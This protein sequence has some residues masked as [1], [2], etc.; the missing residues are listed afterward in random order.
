MTKPEDHLSVR[1]R[2]CLDG[3]FLIAM[4]NMADE[5]F[6]RSVVFICAHSD[7]GAMG[8]IINRPQDMCFSELIS[9]LDLQNAD[10]AR[11]IGRAS[12]DAVDFPVLSGG[13]VDTGRGFVLH[14][15]DYHS[16]ST[17]P[18]SDE[19]CLTATVDILRAIN[20]GRG[21]ERGIMLLGYAGWSPGQLEE[22]MAANSWLSC[23]AND[24]IVFD[25]YTDDKYE[26]VL[27]MMGVQPAMLSMQAGRA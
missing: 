12:G 10:R 8:F 14:S 19:L 18:V 15:D 9:K 22:E 21:P 25:A 23:P 4:P 26:R 13:P 7:D 20:E 17:M 27:K 6:Q 24:D 2:G 11:S 1:E 5:R 16:Q 3:H